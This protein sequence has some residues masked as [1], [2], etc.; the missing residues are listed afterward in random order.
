MK[1]NKIIARIF[2]GLGNQLFCYVVAKSIA[3]ENNAELIIDNITD[4]KNDKYK[5]AYQ[6]KNFNISAR[7]A[8]I[9]ENL[10]PF[11]KLF[12]K[13]LKLISN[14]QPFE[15]R[16]YIRHQGVDFDKRVLNIKPKR[17]TYLEAC[18]QSED[19]FIKHQSL[20]REELKIQAPKDLK[21][22]NLLSQI[23]KSESVFIHFRFFDADINGHN[24]TNIEYYFKAINKIK[25]LV[26]N[27]HFY[28]FSDDIERVLDLEL[29]SNINFTI[30]DINKGQENAFKDLWLMSNC[31]HGIIANSTF[32]WWGGWL[33]GS[34]NKF[35]V[36]PDFRI[37]NTNDTITMW[38]FKGLIPDTWLK[39]KI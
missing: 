32:S 21:N 39:I 38:G 29:L 23:I 30:V 16:I 10:R 26:V 3:L 5:R 4:F 37:E 27:P 9:S 8:F 19:Y 14:F 24:N 22:S 2:G 34:S 1:K 6:L 17:V 15:K 28:I 13:F 7:T 18:W 12:Y 20:I 11:S 35:I 25:S 36:A 31:K 33:I